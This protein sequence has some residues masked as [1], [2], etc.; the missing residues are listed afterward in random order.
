[1]VKASLEVEIPVKWRSQFD[2]NTAR[3]PD[4]GVGRM[5]G[6]KDAIDEVA[7]S[8][9]PVSSQLPRFSGY[10][11]RVAPFPRDREAFAGAF[12]S[13]GLEGVV[14]VVSVRPSTRTASRT[15]DRSSFFFGDPGN[16]IIVLGL[17]TARLNRPEHLFFESYV[18]SN[19]VQGRDACIT[20]AFAAL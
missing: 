11:R 15:N 4:D 7:R 3:T 19:R 14:Q 8:P 1:V 9:R 6:V 18:S 17:R 12:P 10:R 20:I 2:E 13:H 16:L 5:P